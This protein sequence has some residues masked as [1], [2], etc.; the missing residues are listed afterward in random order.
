[1]REN[2]TSSLNVRKLK[3]SR[4]AA[5]AIRPEERNE[6]K[7]VTADALKENSGPSKNDF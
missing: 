3:Y 7:Y 1:M 2:V 5:E 6:A 4:R